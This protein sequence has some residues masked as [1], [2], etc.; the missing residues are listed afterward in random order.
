M[1]S[2]DQAVLQNTT[3][4]RWIILQEATRGGMKDEEQGTRDKAETWIVRVQVRVL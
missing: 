1:L 2:L 4:E 3:G